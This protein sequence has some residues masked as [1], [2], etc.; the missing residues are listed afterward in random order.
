MISSLQTHLAA[1]ASGLARFLN[2]H[3][4]GI[5]GENWWQTHVVTQLTYG[6]QGQVRSRNITHLGGLD[7]AALLKVFDKNWAELSYTAP[8]PNE[9]RTHAKELVDLRHTLAHHASD[10]TSIS[11]GDAFR[12]F[13]T[14][15]R[16][17]V[18]IRAEEHQV[19]AL[20]EAKRAALAS[21]V[22]IPE[23]KA[24]DPQSPP[25]PAA[26]PIVPV[27]VQAVSSLESEPADP[28]ASIQVGAFRLIGPGELIATKISS[29]NGEAVD[30]S[31]VPWQ[32]IGPDGLEFLIHVVLIDEGAGSEF[33]QV[34][35]ESRLGSPQG[36][37]DIVRRLRMGIRRLEEGELI[38]DL[39]CAVRPGGGRATRNVKTL[40]EPDQITGV[41]VSSTLR[42]IGATAV[43]TRAEIANETNKNRN[44]PA[45]SFAADDLATP[46]AA[47][48]LTTLEALNQKALL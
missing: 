13:D 18:A 37:D 16:F 2:T 31:A 43:G 47:W 41:N 19:Q 3:L 42:G 23:V 30:A 5:G 33:G 32:A 48:V 12:H 35:C 15:E 4:P 25:P 8:L 38:L 27:P 22:G 40:A 26:E 6:Q 45:V 14:M 17:M 7:L 34:F 9:T 39:R 24:E 21:M 29:F 46:A 10:G 20:A 36:W 11:V 1:V 44:I 28:L